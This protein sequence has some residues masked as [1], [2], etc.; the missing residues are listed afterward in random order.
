LRAAKLFP[1]L[2]IAGKIR[3]R[4]FSELSPEKFEVNFTV[5]TGKPTEFRSAIR[6]FFLAEEVGKGL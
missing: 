5:A 1:E 4:H 6:A 2:N 3:I